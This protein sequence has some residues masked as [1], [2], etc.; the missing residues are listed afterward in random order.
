VGSLLVFHVLGIPVR[1]VGIRTPD[2]LLVMAV[3]L[4]GS[5]ERGS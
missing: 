2:L 3:R 1:P 4:G 5:S